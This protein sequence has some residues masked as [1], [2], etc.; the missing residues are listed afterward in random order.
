MDCPKCKNKI[1]GIHLKCPHCG[2]NIALF[3]KACKISDYL[4]NKA[5]NM[6]KS[7]NLSGA[8]ESLSRSVL[9]NKGNIQARNLLGLVQ[10]ERG[11]L[12]DA[13]KHWIIS[14]SLQKADNIAKTYLNYVQERTRDHERLNDA[15]KM[16]NK[17]FDYICQKNDDMA[18]IQLKKALD[19]SPKLVPAMNL[20]TLCYIM[21][22]NTQK[23]AAVAAQ[24]LNADSGN[25]VSLEYCKLLSVQ[26]FQAAAQPKEPRRQVLEK[27]RYEKRRSGRNGYFVNEIASFVIG[28][29]CALLILYFLVIPDMTQKN[30]AEI[31]N[32]KESL[33]KVYTEKNENSNQFEQEKQELTEKIDILTAQNES[34][35][36]QVNLYAKV[37]VVASAS[38]LLT[39]GNAIGA[40]DLLF[41]ADLKDIPQDVMEQAA[42][43]RVT[44]FK[45]AIDALYKDGIAKFNEKEF[46]QAKT[47]LEKAQKFAQ[48]SEPAE[49]PVLDGIYYYLGLCARDTEDTQA[50]K[51]YFSKVITEYPKSTW[52]KRATNELGKLE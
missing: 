41:S 17:A 13:L 10:Y 20:L 14:S 34:L 50:A 36:N 15:I 51:N 42:E 25:L 16:Y 29:L 26:S 47:S 12:G 1:D 31:Q 40:A 48:A 9:L 3:Y 19:L 39:S 24:A 2:V 38:R 21:Q 32:L 35:N 22:G 46:A 4:Y 5:L 30:T 49:K 6:A 27:P 18:I 43:M 52:F 45:E 37:Q 8:A 33:E 11:F 7:G 23:A 28:G 44:S